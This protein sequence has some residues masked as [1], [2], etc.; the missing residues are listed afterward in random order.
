[1]F[2]Y[3][4]QHVSFTWIIKRIGNVKV[5]SI[6]CP[7]FSQGLLICISGPS[8]CPWVMITS[9]TKALLFRKEH[10]Y[11]MQYNRLHFSQPSK[12]ILASGQDSWTV[13]GVCRTWP[14]VSFYYSQ[15]NYPG[16][17]IA[18]HYSELTITNNFS[19][20]RRFLGGCVSPTHL[21]EWLFFPRCNHLKSTFWAA[22]AYFL[23]NNAVTRSQDIGD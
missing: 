11:L 16:C 9:V 4:K 5:K 22:W 13:S 8:S 20:K 14:F 6:M 21:K 23:G 1:M 15:N 10:C 7:G 12:W 19:K 17:S 3:M 2:W 18:S